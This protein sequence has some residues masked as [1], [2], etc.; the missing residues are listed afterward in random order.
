MRQQ[1]QWAR[2]TAQ[3]GHATGHVRSGW[4]ASLQA[5]TIP[6]RVCAADSGAELALLKVLVRPRPF[7]THRVLRFFVPEGEY[8]AAD[9]VLPSKAQ[10]GHPAMGAGAT[11]ASRALAATAASHAGAAVPGQ[12]VHVSDAE[13]T[14]E[15][16]ETS[17]GRVATLRYRAGAWPAAHDLHLLLYNDPYGA[18]LHECWHIMVHPLAHH[19]VSTTVGSTARIEIGLQG[20]RRQREA[21]VHVSHPELLSVLGGER[22]ELLPGATNTLRMTHKATEAGTSNMQVHVTDAHTGELLSAWRVSATA[23]MPHISR[24]YTLQVP[25]GRGVMRK[26]EYTNRWPNNCVFHFKTN[27]PSIV[28]VRD[29]CTLTLA[30]GEMGYL[31]LGIGAA[32]TAR[33]EEVL[34]FVNDEDDVNVETCLIR[35]KYVP[36]AYVR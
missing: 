15:V 10:G 18:S 14:V 30:G 32:R 9:I 16:R 12:Y 6:V 31:P 3:G 26:L 29:P 33:Q 4:Q 25:A 23:A 22:L 28:A 5:R 1:E 8:M 20:G 34:L 2:D 35:V 21:R 19:A 13:A 36:S 7:P 27:A 17:D 11:S 24:A